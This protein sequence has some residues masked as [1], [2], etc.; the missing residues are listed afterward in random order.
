[1]DKILQNWSKKPIFHFRQPT[2]FKQGVL[3]DSNDIQYTKDRGEILKVD[4]KEHP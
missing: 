4:G 1:M 3:Q 2:N